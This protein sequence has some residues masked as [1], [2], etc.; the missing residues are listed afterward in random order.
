MDWLPTLLAAAGNE[1]V[2]ED[3]LDG[4]TV[5][6]MAGR[7][8]RV[9]LD[10]HNILPLLTGQS[11]E[12]PREEVFYF[13]D[14]GDLSALRYNDWKITF[15]EQEE[16]GTLRAWIEPF[17]EL[18]TPLVFNLRRDPYERAY[19]TSNTYYDWVLD[20]AF[21][22]VPAQQYVA[23]FIATFEEYPPRQEAARFNLEQVMEKIEE[24]AAGAR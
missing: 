17:T 5:A 23:R 13:T 11:E 1:T 10:G 21:L 7:E 20:H 3:L 4:V 12:S 18:R 2:K 22:L 6:E 8:Y 15:L 19:R 9:H 14:D 24:G 16:W